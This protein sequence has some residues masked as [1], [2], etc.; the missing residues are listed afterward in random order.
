MANFNTAFEKFYGVEQ[1][2]SHDVLHHNKK[3][4]G[5]TFYGIYETAHLS[6]S[7][8]EYVYLILKKVQYKTTESRSARKAKL[9]RASKLLVEN[10]NLI[11][12]V[13]SFYYKKFWKP[14][15][16]DL[17]ESQK[18]AEEMFFFYLNTGNKKRTVLM[19]QAIVGAK[20]DGLIGVETIEK[21]NNY[22]EADFDRFYDLKE[23][24][25]HARLVQSNPTRYLINLVG[26][27][28]RDT[29]V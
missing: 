1:T 21:L 4:K 20:T 17:V 12:E 25:Y 28:R 27:I 3:E 22:S 14:L 15:R 8:W 24:E 9:Q 6:W 29:K 2:G 5:L 19:A 7:G 18:V 13:K 26:W 23:I 11:D 16:L 10:S